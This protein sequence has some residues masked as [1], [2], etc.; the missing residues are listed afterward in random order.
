MSRAIHRCE[1]AGSEPLYQRYD[2]DER[3][4][5]VRSAKVKWI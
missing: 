5:P 3:G 2:D 4:V 1:W